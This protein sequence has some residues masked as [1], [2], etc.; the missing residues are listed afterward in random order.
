MISS[1]PFHRTQMPTGASETDGRNSSRV[2][3]TEALP[4]RDGAF[5]GSALDFLSVLGLACG[6]G[7]IGGYAMLS[8]GVADLEDKR[9]G[10]APRTRSWA[11][12][13]TYHQNHDCGRQQL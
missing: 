7:L 2:N 6:I 5:S 8:A 9:V 10:P 1:S 11:R 4:M 13:A 12:H 3:C